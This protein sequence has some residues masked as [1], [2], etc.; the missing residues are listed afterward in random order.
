VTTL[1]RIVLNRL[2][3]AVRRDLA[4]REQLHKTTMRLLPDPAGPT[5]RAIGGLLYR[6]EPGIEAVLLV[7]TA[8][9]PHLAGLYDGY[10]TA[11]SRDLTG[12]FQALTAGLPVRYRITTAPAACGPASQA[13]PHPRTGRRRGTR[14]ALTGPDATTWW[15]RKATA[16]GL[17]L[18]DEPTASPCPFPQSPTRTAPAPYHHLIRFDGQ[19]TITD[20]AAVAAAVREGIGRG[21]SYG[22]GLLSLAPA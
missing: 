14:H 21:K 17:H 10:G 7:Q 11:H 8:Y 12:M 9:P 6:M 20:P 13:T 1:T 18:A 15:Q 22:A 3:P 19:A 4:D 2:H 5:A 16:A